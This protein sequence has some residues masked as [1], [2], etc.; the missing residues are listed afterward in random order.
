MIGTKYA[1][2]EDMIRSGIKFRA[3][4]TI[5]EMPVQNVPIGVSQ[6]QGR[7]GGP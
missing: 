1:R 7:G 2:L 4:S 5:R 3:F 6:D